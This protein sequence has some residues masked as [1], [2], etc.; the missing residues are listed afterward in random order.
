MSGGNSGSGSGPTGGTT[1]G[2]DPGRGSGSGFGPGSGTG[3]GG[4]GDTL[5]RRTARNSTKRQKIPNFTLVTRLFDLDKFRLR[6][7]KSLVSSV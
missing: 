6:K 5:R 4:A 7:A 2:S 3:I 1:S